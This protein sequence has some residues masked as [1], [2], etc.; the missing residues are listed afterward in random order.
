M[1][2]TNPSHSSKVD[3]SNSDKSSILFKSQFDADDF[4]AAIREC[5]GVE[6]GCIGPYRVLKKLGHG[7]FSTVLKGTLDGKEMVALKLISIN[8]LKKSPKAR[9]SLVREIRA[10]KEHP[11]FVKIHDVFKTNDYICLVMEYIDGGEL[12]NYVADNDGL[13][14]FEAKDI[15]HQLVRAIKYMHSIDLVHRDLKLENILLL[16]SPKKRLLVKIIDFGLTRSIRDCDLLSTRCG[17]EEYT[18]PEIIL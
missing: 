5:P 9:L 13:S 14:A 1:V 17:S 18:A 6:S 11:N 7:S 8:L 4:F 10:L 16:M 3:I 12:F 15:F 2:V